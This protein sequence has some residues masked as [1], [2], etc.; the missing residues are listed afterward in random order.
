MFNNSA[1]L[2]TQTEDKPRRL[3]PPIIGHIAALA[4]AV[5]ITVSF[6]LLRDHIER[7]AIYGYPGIAL[8]TLVGNATV[9]FP[10]PSFAVVFAFGSAL[11][12]YWA[13]IFAGLGAA[14][15]E[16]TG[17]LAGVGG[18]A[19]IQN[20]PIYA[21]LE[22]NMRRYDAWFVFVMAAIPNPFFDIGGMIAGALKM[23]VWKFFLACFAG[24]TIRFI[25]L[26]LS[27]QFIL[28]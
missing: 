5:L 16:M 15:G 13:G 3:V 1:G 20:K 28:G 21:K 25:I 22:R 10:A 18:R 26:A 2:T 14:L 8:V 27:G 24:K 7:L 19:V 23:P 17:Y 9:I 12:P 11:N 6:I 4:A